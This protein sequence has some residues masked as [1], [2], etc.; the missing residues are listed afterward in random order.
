MGR[1]EAVDFDLNDALTRCRA[2]FP[3]MVESFM[4]DADRLMAEMRAALGRGDALQAS[5]LAH[6]LKGSVAYLG[7]QPATEAAR[8]VEELGYAGQTAGLE[9]AIRELG[10]RVDRLKAALAPHWKR[11][12]T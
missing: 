4:S 10:L 3:D 8:R 11:P 1:T 5:R 12:A 9:E 7:A 6:R 2:V